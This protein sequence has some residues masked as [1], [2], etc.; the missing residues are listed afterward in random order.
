[1]HSCIYD[2]LTVLRLAT[3]SMILW[4][5]SKTTILSAAK[6]NVSMRIA[7]RETE[8]EYRVQIVTLTKEGDS[9]RG[10]GRL[11]KHRLVRCHDNI[12]LCLGSS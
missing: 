4:A 9:D 3:V 7:L 12:S 2:R 11:T 1:M 8:T 10:S 5:S 6:R